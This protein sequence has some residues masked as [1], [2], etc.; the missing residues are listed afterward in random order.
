MCVCVTKVKKKKKV[1]WD[2]RSADCCTCPN[3]YSR[4]WKRLA[5]TRHI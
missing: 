5:I 2:S 1:H 4:K 3:R